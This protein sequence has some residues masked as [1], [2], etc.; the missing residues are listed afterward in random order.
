MCCHETD[1]TVSSTFSFGRNQFVG[2]LVITEILLKLSFQPPFQFA[3]VRATVVCAADQNISPD[4]REVFRIIRVVE[5]F[6]YE[7]SPFIRA[8]ISQELHQAIEGRGASKDVERY[9][10]GKF[11]IVRSW[12][13]CDV[14]I[15]PALLQEFVDLGNDLFVRR[16]PPTDAGR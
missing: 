5:K 6:V 15:F 8:G 2:E 12:R 16:G 10:P 11:A 1:S 13:R 14:V 7:S 3:A 9:S 4:R